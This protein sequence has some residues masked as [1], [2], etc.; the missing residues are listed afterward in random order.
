MKIIQITQ[1]ELKQATR[2]NVYRNRKTYTR[3]V[4]HE[5][6]TYGND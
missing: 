3:K 5:T 2:P 1:Q 4:K 6:K